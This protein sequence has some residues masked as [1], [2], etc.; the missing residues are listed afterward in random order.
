MPFA[1][2][3]NTVQQDFLKAS[4]YPS[5]Q[6]QPVWMWKGNEQ[7]CVSMR[8]WALGHPEK[9]CCAAALPQQE[10]LHKTLLPQLLHTRWS[11]SCPVAALK[12]FPPPVPA[13][14]Q[15]LGQKAEVWGYLLS[16][17]T[18]FPPRSS[19]WAFPPAPP[20]QIQGWDN[21]C[22][23]ILV[24]PT[25]QNRC[26]AWLRLVGPGVQGDINTSNSHIPQHINFLIFPVL[27]IFFKHSL[28]FGPLYNLAE[29]L[30][31]VYLNQLSWSI[32][33]NHLGTV[34]PAEWHDPL[35]AG[36][37]FPTALRVR[38]VLISTLQR[39]S[40]HLTTWCLPLDDVKILFSAVLSLLIF[41]KGRSQNIFYCTARG[42]P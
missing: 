36:K 42:M 1:Y 16:L 6:C 2:M 19:L 10:L 17:F 26:F 39:A 3:K 34:S 28:S 11:Y 30:P 22:R 33:T 14:A 5:C 27:S 35:P 4:W 24:I 23:S 40:P 8:Q 38:K 21:M 13:L 31:A 7:R 18:L 37:G 12:C 32:P 29:T 15:L 41:I 9:R 20:H 25:P